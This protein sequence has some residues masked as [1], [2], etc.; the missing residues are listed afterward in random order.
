MRCLLDGRTVAIS[1]LFLFVGAKMGFISFIHVYTQLYKWKGGEKMGEVSVV[2]FFSPVSWEEDVI[3][4]HRMVGILAF[5][6]RASCIGG[7][8]GRG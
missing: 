6:L 5:P 7:R 3:R 8:V 1:S 2:L 4:Q